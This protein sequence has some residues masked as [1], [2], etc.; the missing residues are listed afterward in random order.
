MRSQTDG[1]SMHKRHITPAVG[2]TP[3]ELRATALFVASTF[4]DPDGDE[5]EQIWACAEVLA[6]L[7]FRV[8]QDFGVADFR[9]NAYGRV[10]RYHKAARQ[11]REAMRKARRYEKGETE[12]TEVPAASPTPLRRN[13]T[14]HSLVPTCGSDVGTLRGYNRHLTSYNVPCDACTAARSQ[15]LWNRWGKLGLP[16]HAREEVRHQ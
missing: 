14:R 1:D 9:L 16:E 6:A 2:R 11:P 15:E 5:D 13:V 12:V 7:G 3:Q 4:Y 8:K 10:D